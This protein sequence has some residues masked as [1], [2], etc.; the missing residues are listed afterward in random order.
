MRKLI[1][2]FL[3]FCSG[4]IQFGNKSVLILI[5]YLKNIPSLGKNASVILFL[6]NLH[7]SLA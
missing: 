4:K 1:L 6:R 2:K 7:N 5:Y 3:V